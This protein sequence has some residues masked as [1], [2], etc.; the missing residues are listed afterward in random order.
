MLSEIV[1]TVI[2]LIA[3]LVLYRFRAPIVRALKGFDQSNREK[4]QEERRDR[5]DR[6]AHFRHTLQRAAEQVEEIS[7]IEVTDPRTGIGVPRF[8][9]EA[10]Q[11]ASREDAEQ[12]REKKIRRI[13]TDYYL[14][15]PHALSRRKQ[16]DELN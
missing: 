15:L 12:A 11:F 1:K 5:S 10:E 7:V 13:A 16:K 3:A 4:H 2:V 9:F 14:E 8:I 6:L